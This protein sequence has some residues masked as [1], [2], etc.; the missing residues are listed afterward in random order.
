MVQGMHST[1]TH[2]NSTNN[3]VNPRCVLRVELN[4]NHNETNKRII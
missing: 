4:F 2:I 1:Y 3:E